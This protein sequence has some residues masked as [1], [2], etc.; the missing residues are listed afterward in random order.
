MLSFAEGFIFAMFFLLY[1]LFRI[2]ASPLSNLLKTV[3]TK[4]HAEGLAVTS[5]AS[6]CLRTHLLLTFNMHSKWRLILF[7][8]K[9]FG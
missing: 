7:F 5:F 4:S 1:A 9:P 8:L 6:L 2:L 3:F